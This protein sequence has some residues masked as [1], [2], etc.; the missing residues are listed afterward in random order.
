M[1]CINMLAGVSLLREVCVRSLAGGSC[2][3]N[4]L[5]YRFPSDI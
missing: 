1:L 5:V 4:M 3:A 2:R